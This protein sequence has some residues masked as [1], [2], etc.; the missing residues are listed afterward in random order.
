[1]EL[2]EVAG[3]VAGSVGIDA[4]VDT[5][6]LA[7]AE[8]LLALLDERAAGS[9]TALGL[10][11]GRCRGVLLAGRGEHERAIEV[12]EAVVVEPEPPQG[13][14]PLELGRTLLALG[15]VQRRAQHKRAARETLR[16][17]AERFERLGARLWAAKAR[18]ELRTDRRTHG[19]GR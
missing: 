14:N 6:D 5:G 17:A 3:Q 12:L 7:G 13:V 16:L 11:A 8:R 19:L 10:L 4:L 18:A 9:D 15:T 2:D 1:M